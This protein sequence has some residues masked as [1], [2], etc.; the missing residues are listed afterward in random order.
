MA[1]Y[2]GSAVGDDGGDLD[3]GG[4][5]GGGGCGDECERRLVFWRWSMATVFSV[6]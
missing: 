1:S 2:D 3:G 5:G 6:I 4:G